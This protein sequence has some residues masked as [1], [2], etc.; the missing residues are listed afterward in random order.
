MNVCRVF[1]RDALL[2]KLRGIDS[3]IYDRSVDMLVSRL[4]RKLADDSRS[5]RFI[6]T[7][8]GAGY[9]FVGASDS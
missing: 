1:S 7:L 5:P 4:R 8:R 3:S 6:R 9:Q 2:R